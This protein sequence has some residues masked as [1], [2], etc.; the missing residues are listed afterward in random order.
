M[1]E[2]LVGSIFLDPYPKTIAPTSPT[3][4]L[5]HFLR[6]IKTYDWKN[7]PMIIDTD[8]SITPIEMDLIKDNFS[9]YR[10][11]CMANGIMKLPM[12]IV[13]SS[14]R[15]IGF[16][17]LI[18]NHDLTSPEMGLLIKC[19]LNTYSILTQHLL[20]P[21]FDQN[22][23]E[24]LSFE[25]ICDC[26][27]NLVRSRFNIMLKFQADLVNTHTTVSGTTPS[28]AMLQS[29]KNTPVKKLSTHNLIVR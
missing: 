8:K 15:N 19:S 1:V 23:I 16:Q 14:S 9:Q 26:T 11:Q 27:Q 5:L 25:S 3:V 17:P 29:F 2:L 20:T 10:Q 12:Y 6:L 22:I 18:W 13:T 24:D 4:A 28:F 7:T 21:K